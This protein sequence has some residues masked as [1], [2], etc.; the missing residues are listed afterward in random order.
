M[1]TRAVIAKP[2]GDGFRG[3]YHHF[4]GYPSGLGVAL[5]GTL[6]EQ[7]GG[8]LEA[9]VTRLIDEEHVGWSNI[10]GHDLSMPSCWH[11]SSDPAA[12]CASCT[13]PMWRHYAQYYP[14]GTADDPV[15]NG[16]RR[17]GLIH[18]EQ[19]MQLGHSFEALPP[20]PQGPQSYTARGES[21]QDGDYW[22]TNQG[23]DGGTEW[24]YV[25][26]AGGVLVVKREYLS[27][28]WRTLALV[29]WNDASGMD[30][31]E[32]AYYESVDACAG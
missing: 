6:A 27:L 18:P 12:L 11:D 10:I 8:D 29:A 24:A 13:L 2:D 23:D 26:S 1:S 3:R 20:E 15:V 7:F 9:M 21:A 14:E 5:V 25:L 28:T 17:A 22:I 16:R 4:D 19:V 32:T 31:I 30:A